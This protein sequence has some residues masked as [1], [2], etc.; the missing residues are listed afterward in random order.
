MG[1]G[2]NTVTLFIR[3]LRQRFSIQNSKK[4]SKVAEGK[5]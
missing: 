5:Y 1:E 4:R 3:F 2:I